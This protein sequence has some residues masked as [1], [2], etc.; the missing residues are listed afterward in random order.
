MTT[1]ASTWPLLLP[2]LAIL[3]I[4]C[5]DVRGSKLTPETFRKINSSKVLTGE[6]IELLRA[7]IVRTGVAT[8]LANSFGSKDGAPLLDSTVTVREAIKAQ[9]TW[10]R[11]DSVREAAEKKR[12]AD[13]LAAY[14][15]GMQKLRHYVTATVVKKGFHEYDYNS[16]NTVQIVLANNGEKAVRAVKGH[17]RVDDLFGDLIVRLEVKED[18]PIEPGK[19]VVRW[20][21]YDYNQFMDRDTKFRA[22]ELDKVKITWEPEII[23]LSDGSELRVPPQPE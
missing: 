21:S 13:A 11:D 1:R 18:V 6:E 20:S 7:Y 22:A 17:L 8:A 19:Q 23:L 4:A 9:R 14:E 15:A 5:S 10:L 16:Y 3:G 12:A 2:V